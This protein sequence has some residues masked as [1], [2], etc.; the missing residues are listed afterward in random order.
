MGSGDEWGWQTPPSTDGGVWRSPRSG[1][2]FVSYRW[3]IKM[4]NNPHFVPRHWGERSYWWRLQGYQAS[5]S[6]H[7][8]GGL[9]VLG[10]QFPRRQERE[11]ASAR[12]FLFRE[13]VTHLLTVEWDHCFRLF[14]G[15]LSV[16]TNNACS[17]PS[18]Y[19][20][21]WASSPLSLLFI[22]RDSTV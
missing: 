4:I 19:I 6:R 3:F 2:S 5:G 22:H 9:H 11:R 18:P 17:L 13:L 8:G 12:S 7:G 16:N 20:P 1:W 14:P 21:H 10:R 15:Q